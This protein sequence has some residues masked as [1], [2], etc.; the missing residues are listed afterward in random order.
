M[1]PYFLNFLKCFTKMYS[2]QYLASIFNI[3]SYHNSNLVD[4][5]ELKNY[6]G[7]VAPQAM[8]QLPQIYTKI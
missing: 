6:P 7:E 1:A 2:K 8:G 5:E 4:N 3:I